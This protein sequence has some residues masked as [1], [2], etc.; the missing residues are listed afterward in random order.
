MKSGRCQPR[1]NIPSRH[2]NSPCAINLFA[3]KP[4]SLQSPNDLFHRLAK[5][6]NDRNRSFEP[7]VAMIAASRR[8]FRR[9]RTSLLIGAGVVTAGYV[10]GQ[11][12]VNK[13]QEARQRISE[14]RISKEK[15]EIHKVLICDEELIAVS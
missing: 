9:N 15:Y 13:I 4:R 11:Y 2:P 5:S 8:W 12:V 14:E 1:Y 6:S 10:A 3:I 7:N